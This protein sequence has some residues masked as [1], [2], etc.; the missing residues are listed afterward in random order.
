ML[1]LPRRPERERRSPYKVEVAGSIPAPPTTSKPG[2]RG[3]VI[4]VG[5]RSRGNDEIAKG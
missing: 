3:S 2:A 5:M 1:A 4:L